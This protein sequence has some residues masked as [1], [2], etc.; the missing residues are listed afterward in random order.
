[1]PA[2]VVARKAHKFPVDNIHA[3]EDLSV[4]IEQLE[5]SMPGS[6]VRAFHV[7]TGDLSMPIEQL[8]LSMPA[9]AVAREARRF[10]V[11]CARATKDRSMPIEQL[12]FSMLAFAA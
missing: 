10:P 6:A 4:P 3:T 9:P 8:E 5:S 7:T 11:D 1:M 2:T 12:E